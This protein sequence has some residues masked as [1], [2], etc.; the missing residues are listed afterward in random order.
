MFYHTPS[1]I[2]N[3]RENCG[4]SESRVWKIIN[5]FGT[6]AYRLTPLQALLGGDAERRY[7]WRNFAVNQSEFQPTLLSDI[8]GTDEAIFSRNKICNTH[9]WALENPK[10]SATFEIKYAFD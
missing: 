1:H 2:S 3:T 5:E 7:A 4:L 6:H 9:Y 10:C 8:I